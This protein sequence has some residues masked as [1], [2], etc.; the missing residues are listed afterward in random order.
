[1]GDLDGKKAIVV[2]A[3]RGLGRG[4]AETLSRS[5]DAS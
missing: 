5:A 3:S 4:I 2:G 1:M